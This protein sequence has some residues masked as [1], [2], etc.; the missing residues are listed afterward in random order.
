MPVY[1]GMIRTARHC[2]VDYIVRYDIL[3][4]IKFL[5]ST[6]EIVIRFGSILEQELGVILC[7]EGLSQG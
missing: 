4:S 6:F 3:T 2:I 5:G 7:L 1:S